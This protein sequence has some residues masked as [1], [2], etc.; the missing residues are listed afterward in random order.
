MSRSSPSEWSMKPEVNLQ[1]LKGLRGF[2]FGR[3]DVGLPIMYDLYDE[4]YILYNFFRPFLSSS[5]VQNL[6]RVQTSVQAFTWLLGVLKI[7][8]QS[9]FFKWSSLFLG[10]TKWPSKGIKPKGHVHFYLF[11]LHNFSLLLYSAT[12]WHSINYEQPKEILPTMEILWKIQ[13]LINRT[14][15][16]FRR[17]WMKWCSTK[18][19][20]VLQCRWLAQWQMS[21]W[22]SKYPL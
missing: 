3:K 20:P 6:Q 17:I 16:I 9:L 12:T 21:L 18:N 22:S 15:P 19:M 1:R 4:N 10:R 7:W 13:T 14:C 11:F 5:E 2:I 8:S